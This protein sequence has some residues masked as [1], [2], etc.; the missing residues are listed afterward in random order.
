MR[1]GIRRIRKIVRAMRGRTPKVELISWSPPGNYENFGDFLSRI[2]IQKILAQKG[3]A[4]DLMLPRY[5]VLRRPI[6]L[7]GIGSI[8]HQAMN[9]D[10]IWGS[11]INGKVPDYS[12]RFTHL[13]VR[14]VRGP[15]T[16]EFLTRRGINCPDVFGDPG[17][18]LPRLFPDIKKT[19]ANREYLVIPNFNDIYRLPEQVK[20][21]ENLVFPTEPW[22]TVIKRILS[23]RLVIAS[24]L[25]GIVMADAFGV[26]ARA[27][28]SL[29]EPSFKYYDYYE[30]T[31]RATFE[32][33]R[34]ID[35]AIEMGGEPTICFHTNQLLSVFPFDLWTG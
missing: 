16:K 21:N 29:H 27:L 25:H 24:S 26:P 22:R 30:G 14:S 10:V 15:R 8:L 34:S 20:M 7:F 19:E 9:G 17:L 23:S 3:L 5:A 6:R 2:I 12:H 1:T 33:A 28:E 35:E 32:F 13:D 18:L 31:G 11:G 4:L